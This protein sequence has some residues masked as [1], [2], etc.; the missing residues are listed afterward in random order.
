MG[1]RSG[2][3]WGM[4]TVSLNFA[5]RKCKQYPMSQ[6]GKHSKT[7]SKTKYWKHCSHDSCTKGQNNTLQNNTSEEDEHSLSDLREHSS[8]CS[9]YDSFPP[10]VQFTVAGF[11]HTVVL[12]YVLF[13]LFFECRL[14]AP[15]E[16]R[17]QL[18]RD[19]LEPEAFQR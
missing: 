2:E 8:A 9:E 17:A 10:A 6:K 11:Q 12:R 16:H 15:S 18:W 19:L 5:A 1:N 13:L 4:R 14:C 3:C 7:V